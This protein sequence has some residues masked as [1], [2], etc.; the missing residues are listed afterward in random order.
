MGISRLASLSLVGALT[1]TA[2]AATVS[3]AAPPDDSPSSRAA[4]DSAYALV[5]LSGDPLATAP[6]TRPAQGKKVDFTSRAV[7]NERARLAQERNA[8]KAWLRKNAPAAKVSAELDVA[9]NAVGVELN[10]TAIETLR[11]APGV[12]F[13]EAQGVFTPQ[14]HEDP[15]L[16]VIKGQQAWAAVS[17]EAGAGKGVKVAIIDSGIDL[18]HPCFDDEGFTSTAQLGDTSLTNNKVIVAR[19]YS[20][21]LAKNGFGAKD[22]NGHGT[23]VAG[24]V[25]CNAHTPAAIQGREIPY[26]PSG[27][28]PAAQLG[29]YNVFPG[30][31]GSARSQ[32]ILLAMQDAYA[33]GFDVANMSLGGGMQ[34]GGQL[35]VNAIE[36]LD[37]A[38]M[39]MAVA[40]GNEGPGYFT[41]HWPGAAERALTVGAS[42][43]GHAFVN[44]VSVGEESFDMVIGEFGALEED[45]TA[46]LAV[47]A[48]ASATQPHTLSLACTGMPLGE[49]ADAIAVIGRGV[50][51]F[52]EKV[53]NAAAAGAVGVI[54]VNSDETYLTMAGDG[55]GIP[56][57]LVSLS[58]GLEIAGHDGDPATLHAV[59]A[60]QE[61][62]NET[63]LMASFSSWGPT[64]G[65]AL[66]KPD[67]VAPGGNILSAAPAWACDAEVDTKGCWAFNSG[68][69]MATPHVAGIAAVVRGEHPDWTAPQVRSA[70]VNTAQQDIVRIPEEAAEG[71]L[72]EVVTNDAFIVGAG[73]ADAEAAVQVPVALE[74][75][76]LSFGSLSSGAGRTLSKSMT[77]TNT[78]DGTRNVTVAL[79]DAADDVTY[80]VNGGSATLASGEST[81][82]TV[83]AT[84]VKRA[85]AGAYQGQLDVSVGGTVV[86]HA[87][88]QTLVGQG[89]T[90]PGQW[91]TPPGLAAVAS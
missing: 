43:V 67:V 73:L 31:S 16:A 80:S 50:C 15:Q 30:E 35:L 47:V 81:T 6:G 52:Q 49:L 33:D 54:V 41:V 76:S 86:A 70:V 82:V 85:A 59:G 17:G 83:T 79:S 84:T 7:K 71:V 10:G 65:T 1:L 46:P 19:A 62:P 57:V 63:N 21:K 61:Y 24:T 9:L 8:F 23:H 48:D 20:N 42:N 77:I 89:L 14:A 28:A 11:K 91:T 56:A 75:V 36:N 78:T 37:K 53:D 88:L 29:N 34:E 72:T 55:T 58:D 38:N 22:L 68:T 44:Q 12:S 60:Y 18:D 27:V 4:V 40:A 90:A 5:Q 25:A 87:M 13:V 64:P 2:G 39:V 69:S 26:D 74:P 3:A 45:L 51:S 32:D 66:V